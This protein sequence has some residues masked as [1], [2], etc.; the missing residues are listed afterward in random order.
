MKSKLNL[1]CY[2]NIRRKGFIFSTVFL[3]VTATASATNLMSDNFEGPDK[4][5]TDY[6]SYL[7][8]SFP[9]NGTSSASNPSLN[10]EGDSGVFYQQGNWGYSGTPADWG[11]Q[12][13]FR[14]NTRNF[15]FQDVAI[16]WKYKS[17][18][19]GENGYPVESS[20]AVDVWLRYQT[21]Y[22]LYAFQFDRT[23]DCFQIKRKIPA[24]GWSGPSN[25]IA[26]KGVYYTLPTDSAQPIFG[27]GIYCVTWKGVQSIL[28]VSEKSK[29]GFP[30][31]AHDAATTY[32][33]K[34]TEK[35]LS[36]GS[37]QFQ[38]Y[39]GGVLFYSATDTGRNGISANGEKQAV[40]MDAGFYKTVPGWQASWGLPITKAGASG[41]RAD[42]V[43]IWIKN[44][45]VDSLSD[46]N[47]TP[48]PVPT[49]IVTPTPVPTLP[50]GNV[51]VT[52][53][54]VRT[55]D[56]GYCADINVKNV[57]NQVVKS[58]SASLTI[59]GTKSSIW[60]AVGTQSGNILSIKNA[61]WNGT[62]K[63][64]QILLDPG[65]C[66]KLP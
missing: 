16:S 43:K 27:A 55:W 63:P 61:S 65:Y 24:Q 10:W 4:L 44:F 45:S 51:V 3:A 57:S 41:F 20:N 30:H 59:K 15:N 39:R 47:P 8:A 32:D 66:A 35:N 54:I 1:F 58:W 23:D 11:N 53:K 19:Y 56:S 5:I 6:H 42:N 50:T 9:L 7:F 36:N 21:Q 25:L 60:N 33:F 26:N 22:N 12:W 48:T 28:P 29:L 40:H 17:A 37:V 2:S 64:G 49:V 34:V 62:L 31:L 52:S 46:V 14:F 13:F 38:A 18:K